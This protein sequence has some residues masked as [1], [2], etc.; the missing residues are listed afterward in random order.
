[1]KKIFLI[2][3]L[4]GVGYGFTKFKA[5]TDKIETAQKAND[6][7]AT[8]KWMTL[9]QAIAAQAKK[10]KKIFMDAYTDWCGPCKMLDAKT[11]NNPD[12]VKYMNENYYA[13]K[14]DAE[15]NESIKYK[16][17]TYSNPN[18]DPAKDK[19]RNSSHQLA[20]YFQVRSY[21]T[22]LFFDEQANVLTPIVGYM[23]PQQLE[24][25]LKLFATN[26]YK[27]V[28]TKEEWEAYQKKFKSDFK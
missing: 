23:T 7:N 14:F 6:D 27:N 5:T 1:M 25:Y 11:F 26:D 17:K 4:I 15:G 22:M 18:Y 9:E 16:G 12:L 28:K 21:P 19:A 3:L 20:G 2:V 8:I 10:P 24:I 13:V